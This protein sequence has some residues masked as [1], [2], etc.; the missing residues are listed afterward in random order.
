MI[1]IQ[2]LI[3]NSGIG[4]GE[5]ILTGQTKANALAKMVSSEK[6]NIH[7]FKLDICFKTMYVYVCIYIYRYIADTHICIY[8]YIYI[9]ISSFL[10]SNHDVMLFSHCTSA[11][12]TMFLAG[13]FRGSGPLERSTS[14]LSQQVSMH[15]Q[16][17]TLT[18][19]QFEHM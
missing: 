12:Q 8:I 9:S 13:C 11:I 7:V 4:H 15:E 6:K 17:N 1:G 14:L 19:P 18:C 3:A 5:T 2:S 16:T 10:M